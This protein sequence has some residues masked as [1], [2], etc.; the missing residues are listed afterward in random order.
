MS[1][2]ETSK[3]EENLMELHRTAEANWATFSYAK[4]DGVSS[5]KGMVALGR[6]DIVRGVV[7]VVKKHGGE[8]N[9]HYH[10]GISSFWM[11]LKG[12]VRFYGPDDVVLG[13]FGPHE[14]MITPRF[15]R[16]WF[17]NIGEDD[18]EILQVAAFSS[19]K[20]EKSGRTDVSEQRFQTGTA[21]HFEAKTSPSKTTAAQG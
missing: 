8:N 3:K 21:Q 14:G 16:Y 7:Q 5:G 9:L 20:L 18:L 19:D 6:K 2:T 11:V 12:R 10:T 15:S 17:E 4:P 1:T 13:E